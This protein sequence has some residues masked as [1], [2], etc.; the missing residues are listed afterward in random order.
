MFEDDAQ[1]PPD[2]LARL[3]AWTCQLPDDWEL[4]LLGW[5]DRGGS[6]RVPGSPDLRRVRR[7]WMLHAY[8]INERGMRKLARGAGPPVGGQI[9]EVLS[10]LAASNLPESRLVVYG[11][12][13]EAQRLRQGG[14]D[15]IADSD[16][17]MPLQ[18]GS[19]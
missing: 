1:V 6:S 14:H 13:D 18:D 17:S 19:S 10:A 3:A 12:D 2:F 8:L 15:G 16:V 4:L 9:D 5:W 11:V 7:F